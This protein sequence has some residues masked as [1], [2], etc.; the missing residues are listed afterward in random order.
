MAETPDG[1][2]VLLFGGQTN[3]NFYEDRILEL[4]A[5]DSS[6]NILNITLEIGRRKHE[7]QESMMIHFENMQYHKTI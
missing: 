6:W 3:K 7:I 2:G 5:G 1:R 4:C